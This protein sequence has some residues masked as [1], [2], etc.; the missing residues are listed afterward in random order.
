MLKLEALGSSQPMHN[1]AR[2]P[3]CPTPS[4]MLKIYVFAPA[5]VS[6]TFSASTGLSFFH[7]STC[8][9]CNRQLRQSEAPHTL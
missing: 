4:S 8:R 5:S 9:A 7:R 3:A 6:H 2:T 1:T